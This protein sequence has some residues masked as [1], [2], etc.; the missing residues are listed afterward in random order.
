MF[1]LIILACSVLISTDALFAK[2]SDWNGLKVTW[3]PNPLSGAY[4][5]SLPRTV[6][7][8]ITGGFVKVSSCNETAAWRGERYVRNND[9]SIVLLFD[10]NGYI[11]G[12]Q[13]SLKQENGWPTGLPFVADGD[14]FTVSAYFVDPS[15]ICKGGRSASDFQSQGTGTGL[16]IQRT[17]VPEASEQIPRQEPGLMNSLWTKGKCF[18]TMGMHYWYNLSENMDCKDFFPVFL[19][20]NKGE[21]NAF[22]WAL[23]SNQTSTTFEHPT[24][25]V[26]GL[27]MQ[28]PPKC[29][30]TAG[31]LS[32]Q[33][34][35]LT[36]NELADFC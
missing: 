28:T 18:I 10:V 32:T 27:F 5:N 26:F 21:L 20:Y 3:G 17:A 9:Y 6:S 15:I 34:I 13:T 24:Q 11:A 29:L 2:A 35:Y 19:L 4:F 25:S 30:S 33:H 36:K 8:A 12:M 23:Q 7:D 22:G 16:Y 1:S 31:T 14:R